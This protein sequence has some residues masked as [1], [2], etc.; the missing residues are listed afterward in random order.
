PERVSGGGG[1]P[2][3]SAWGWGPTR[4][5]KVSAAMIVAAALIVPA[6]DRLTAQSGAKNGEWR[7]YGADTGNTRYSPLDQITAANF[8]DLQIAWRFKADALGS[9]PEYQLEA[10]PLMV[11]GVVYSTAGTRRAVV[12]LD[13]ATG[14]MLWMHSERE[15]P[16][17]ASAPRQLSGRGL[18]YWSDGANDSRILYVTPGYRLI[19]LNA[20]TGVPVVGFGDNGVVDL[21]NA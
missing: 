7:H 16:R 13:A 4:I 2:P 9:R 11:G 8:K 3:A 17:G 20:K 1:A 5:R 21:K 12:A 18:A 6:A 10:T 19:A 15:G 14:E